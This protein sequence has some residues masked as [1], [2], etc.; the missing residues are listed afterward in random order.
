MKSG[1]PAFSTH[2]VRPTAGVAGSPPTPAPALLAAA[3]LALDVEMGRRRVL[4]RARIC[5]P[6]R[7]TP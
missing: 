4:H 3:M 7:A 1:S 5:K 6:R 2:R